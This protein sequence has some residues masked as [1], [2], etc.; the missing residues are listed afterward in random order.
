LTDKRRH[1]SV[2]EIQSFSEADF[3]MGHYLMVTKVRKRLAVCK[4]KIHKFNTERFNINKLNEVECKEQ[5]RVETSYRF[6]ALENLDDDVDNNRAWETIRENI[7]ISA[8][9][10]LGY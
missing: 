5:Y 3:D 7:K 6:T 10:C 4:Q 8:K 2:L 1:S 9:E